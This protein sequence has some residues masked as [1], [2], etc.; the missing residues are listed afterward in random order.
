L[1]G[2]PEYDSEGP[3]FGEVCEWAELSPPT[4]SKHLRQ[5]LREGLIRKVYNVEGDRDEFVVADDKQR[6]TYLLR[7]FLERAKEKR[8]EFKSE[9]ER[10]QTTIIQLQ[11]YLEPFGKL[12]AEIRELEKPIMTPDIYDDLISR[13]EALRKQWDKKPSSR[14]RDI[15]SKR[16][17]NSRAN[18]RKKTA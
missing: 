2:P 8:E 1:F 10:L 14:L 5:L 3:T 6:L 17:P 18:S 16:P 9:F 11:K 12:P 15:A 13:A 7:S 4:V